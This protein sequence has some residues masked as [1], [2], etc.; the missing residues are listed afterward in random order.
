MHLAET[1]FKFSSQHSLEVPDTGLTIR[2]RQFLVQLQLPN[3]DN[4]LLLPL[5]SLNKLIVG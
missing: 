1:C 4:V 5:V 3:Y 2:A